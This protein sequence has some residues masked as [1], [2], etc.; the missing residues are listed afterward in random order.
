MSAPKS[1]VGG[2]DTCH[3]SFILLLIASH[4]LLWARQPHAPAVRSQPTG[5]RVLG[6]ARHLT[7]ERHTS[8]FMKSRA[9]RLA[10]AFSDNASWPMRACPAPTQVGTIAYMAPEVVRTTAA[11]DGACADI[12]SCGIMLYVMLFG[13][14]PFDAPA[15]ARA[16]AAPMGAKNA[17][18]FRH[19]VRFGRVPLCADRLHVWIRCLPTAWTSSAFC[20][21]PTPAMQA[22]VFAMRTPW[23]VI[24]TGPALAMRTSVPA[25]QASVFAMRMPALAMR[26]PAPAMRMS[27]PAMQTSVLATWM[28]VIAMQTSMLA[29][30]TFVLALQPSAAQGH[31]A[32]A[33]ALIPPRLRSPRRARP[34]PRR[35]PL[36][37]TSSRC[38]G[39]SQ[40]TP[41]SRPSAATCWHASS[42]QSRARGCP[43]PTSCATR[44][45][46]PTC[47]QRR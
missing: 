35:R 19:Q 28:S 40:R 31:P 32:A 15:A 18:A 11:Y 47:R 25:M 27:A 17:H 20:A 42:W 6:H 2:A 21:G 43:W 7:A 34:P 1:K 5:T 39:P 9:E 24:R 4:K 36:S 29:M 3:T 22:S 14:Y 30:Q 41:P 38:G 45:S 8:H 44:G 33:P 10:V 37:T 46:Q 26:T 16:A 23:L 12:W 13:A